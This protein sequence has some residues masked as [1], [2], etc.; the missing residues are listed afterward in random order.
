MT[1]PEPGKLLR[2]WSNVEDIAFGPLF[3]QY[4]VLAT[5]LW[6]FTQEIYDFDRVV[7][8]ASDKASHDLVSTRPIKYL[9]DTAVEQK[10]RKSLAVLKNN[11]Q[12]GREVHK[13]HT[14]ILG[15]RFSIE[16]VEA[17]RDDLRRSFAENM[18]EH[19]IFNLAHDM[20]EVIESAAENRFSM[21][22]E[23]LRLDAPSSS[24]EMAG[25][26][27]SAPSCSIEFQTTSLI[28]TYI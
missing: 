26:G 25:E 7:T 16:A 5:H 2:T 27:I 24:H 21:V 18:K 23:V 9:K 11:V 3:L 17:T 6:N 28:Y 1:I 15:I 14:S 22:D 4:S 8:G 19:E 10:L 13:V 20:W 12:L